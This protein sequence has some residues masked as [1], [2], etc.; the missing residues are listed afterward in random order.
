MIQ[1][2]PF[3]KG[4]ALALSAMLVVGG[5]FLAQPEARIE[6][7]GGGETAEARMGTAFE[8]MAV[9]TL[10]AQTVEDITQPPKPPVET[11]EPTQPIETPRAQ[12]APQGAPLVPTPA[13]APD[14]VAP[15]PTPPP[16]EASVVP[17]PP[18]D[19][20]AAQAPDS[21]APQLSVRPQRR[22]PEKAAEV[23]AARPD[24][25]P[26]RTPEPR[27]A[28]GNAQRNN[29]QGADAGRN[30]QAQARSQ[31]NT[32]QAATQ[33]GNAAASNYPGEV[34]RKISRVRKP[35]VRARGT[36]TISFRIAASGGLAGISVARSSGSAAL[37]QAALRVV[38]TA[39]PFPSPPA[40]AGRNFS[41]QIQG[42]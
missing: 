22:D 37:D 11:V 15:G 38:Q 8:D 33:S 12:A 7:A 18:Q 6:M 41:I 42:R 17:V 30:P 4:V 20:I 14:G 36:A 9:G 5:M 35:N 29:T 1:S 21:T 27:T 2:S 23:A 31:G 10:T 34:M 3:A 26:E 16:V 13:P 32:R 25:T 39:A 40:G 24:P 19:T 28:R